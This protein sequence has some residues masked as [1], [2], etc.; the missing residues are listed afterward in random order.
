[1]PNHYQLIS[2]NGQAPSDEF[3]LGLEYDVDGE[4][5]DEEKAYWCVLVSTPYGML[6]GKVCNVKIICWDPLLATYE[7]THSA[8]ILLCTH[9]V[10]SAVANK[11]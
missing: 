7:Y 11:R 3:K 4:R 8:T 9:A 10:L 1:M 2:N 5:G 6:P